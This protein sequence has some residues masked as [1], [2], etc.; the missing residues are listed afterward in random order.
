MS[1]PEPHCSNDAGG[2]A[3]WES[4]SHGAP[5]PTEADL[6]VAEARARSEEWTAHA[7]VDA[8][9][10]HDKGEASLCVGEAA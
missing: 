1:Q 10:S 9:D 6:V 7:A 3:G 8:G 2:H 5:A 4:G